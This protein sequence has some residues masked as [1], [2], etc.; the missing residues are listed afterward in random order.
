MGRRVAP[1][2]AL[3]G[4]GVN[5]RQI[6]LPSHPSLTSARDGEEGGIAEREREIGGA[7][8]MEMRPDAAA[9]HV[10]SGKFKMISLE[11]FSSVSQ[12]AH[13]NDVTDCPIRHHSIHSL[14]RFRRRF[15]RLERPQ[16]SHRF[17]SSWSSSSSALSCGLSQSVGCLS[18]RQSNRFLKIHNRRTDAEAFGLFPSLPS[19]APS[20]A[21][22]ARSLP[23][24]AFPVSALLAVTSNWIR[25][26]AR[27]CHMRKT[28]SRQSAQLGRMLKIGRAWVYSVDNI[29][30]E[31]NV[32]NSSE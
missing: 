32:V 26:T 24:V 11:L 3:A 4:E 6:E 27:R 31:K 7:R 8:S 28:H 15:P 23:L 29:S 10:R 13:S 2:H 1:P 12:F 17:S 5:E 9:K 20:T 22:I 16:I 19:Y 18:A 14:P 21:M 25:A 30:Y